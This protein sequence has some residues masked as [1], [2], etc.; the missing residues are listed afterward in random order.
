MISIDYI[1]RAVIAKF[2]AMMS[3]KSLKRVEA[4]YSITHL[5]KQIT[6]TTKDTK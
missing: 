1:Q 3:P 2:T 4:P 5:L 6:G